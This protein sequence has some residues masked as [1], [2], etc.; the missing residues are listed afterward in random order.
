M[1]VGLAFSGMLNL[2]ESMKRILL[3][4]ASIVAFAGAAA[5]QTITF[6]GDAELGF[7][8][9]EE[10]GFFYSANLDVTFQADLGGGL[11][12]TVTFT[13]P[14][15]DNVFGSDS[16]ATNSNDFVLA[17]AAE[18]VGG[19]FFGDTSF[20]PELHWDPGFAMS[21]DGFSEQ[22]NETVLR[23]QGT[24]FG[25]AMDTSGI[26]RDGDNDRPGINSNERDYID[27]IA[28]GASGSVGLFTMDIAYQEKSQ[29]DG[30]GV[31]ADNGTAGVYDS[32]NPDFNGDEVFGVAAGATFGG[33]DVKFGY[34]RNFDNIGEDG[35]AGTNSYGLLVRYPFGPVSLSASYTFEPDYPNNSY[36]VAAD[37]VSGP[38]SVSAYY[39]AEATLDGSDTDNEYGV[40][41]VY[42]QSEL[43]TYYIGYIDDT[44]E[45][46]E[47]DGDQDEGFY[48]AARQG[49]GSNA[50]VEASYSEFTDAGPNEVRKGT[51]V[52]VGLTF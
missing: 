22:D 35:D 39:Q 43:T 32:N 14:V 12:S 45:N 5:A 8:D 24:F 37:Y 52:L 17:L 51:T 15:A 7:N 28:V 21:S 33:A 49:L 36:K 16:T 4:S 47:L 27:Q 9:D 26:V 13:I 44:N 19:L 18:G 11:T 50:Y 25:F 2:R 1:L 38:I 40:E 48:V 42:S 34:S 23:A 30:S 10:D 41:A 3:A 31:D 29:I 6:G 46:I 20:A